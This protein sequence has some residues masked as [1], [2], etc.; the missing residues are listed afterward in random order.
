MVCLGKDPED[1][2]IFGVPVDRSEDTVVVE[3][4]NTALE[5]TDEV[6]RG[7]TETVFEVDG[8]AV[9]SGTKD[10]RVLLPVN[11]AIPEVIKSD[12]ILFKN[13]G[14]DEHDEAAEVIVAELL[15]VRVLLGGLGGESPLIVASTTST[16]F[17]HRER[18]NF[19][20]PLWIFL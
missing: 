19:E 17:V 7:T 10:T 18:C 8:T 16:A 15:L 20:Q 2:I 6:E 12:V 9:T 5:K 3:V 4:E 14:V 11:V 1:K 13:T